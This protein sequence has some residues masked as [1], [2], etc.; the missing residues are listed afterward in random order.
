MWNVGMAEP[1]VSSSLQIRSMPSPN[2]LRE[3]ALRIL[4]E[5]EDAGGADLLLAVCLGYEIVVLKEILHGRL[6]VTDDIH[7]IADKIHVNVIDRRSIDILVL[8][9]TFAL[10]IEQL[11]SFLEIQLL[12]LIAHSHK[13]FVCLIGVQLTAGWN[14]FAVEGL[15]FLACLYFFYGHDESV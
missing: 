6:A 10:V 1:L 13:A 2:S 15:R 9:V 5:K 7:V 11:H 3:K 14:A 8:I 12:A 4:A